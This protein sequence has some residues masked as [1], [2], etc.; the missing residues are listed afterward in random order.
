MTQQ[1]SDKKPAPTPAE[2]A[3]APATDAAALRQHLDEVARQRD[4]AY[5][6]LAIREADLAR[7]QRIAGIGG[8]EVD[9]TEGFNSRHSPEYLA[10]HGLPPDSGNETHEGWLSRIHPDDRERMRQYFVDA[11]RGPSAE[12][13]CEYRIIRRDNGQVRWVGVRARI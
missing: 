1:R 12:Y 9:L 3:P 7:I 11:I 5:Q 2:A 13:A 10:I 4:R 8:V 6:A